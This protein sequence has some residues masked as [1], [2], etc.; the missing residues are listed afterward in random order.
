VPTDDPKPSRP[1]LRARA[2][3]ELERHDRTLPEA[4]GDILRLAHELRVHHVELEMQNESLRETQHELEEALR[5]VTAAKEELEERVAQRT[6][7]LVLANERALAA[8]RAKSTFLSMMG[9]ELRTPMNGLLG[10]VET[11]LRRSEDEKTREQL[12]VALTS[13]RHLVEIL[14]D[15]LDV[16]RL[17]T[18]EIEL[19]KQPFPLEDVLRF[20][21]ETLEPAA[22]QKEL[23]FHTILSDGLAGRIVW[24]DLLRVAR[25]SSI[26]RATQSSSR[27]P[28]RSPWSPPSWRKTPRASWFVSTC[29]TPGSGF[30]P[31]RR[32]GCSVSSSS[33]A[34]ARGPTRARASGAITSNGGRCGREQSLLGRR[35][36]RP[37]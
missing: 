9:H 8:S 5:Q 21:R 35:A 18:G 10:M 26:W 27:R 15:I 23:S 31:A 34:R 37:R 17:D 16:S 36:P 13:G 14:N 11:V 4:S 29:A 12:R 25:S 2:E 19:S 20:A 7:E 22:R 3:A 32:R 1:T 6:A 33:T 30:R 28:V 24:G